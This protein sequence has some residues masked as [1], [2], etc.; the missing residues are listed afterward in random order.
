VKREYGMDFPI[1][2]LDGVNN[3]KIADLLPKVGHLGIKY[4]TSQK[5]VIQY[6]KKALDNDTSKDSMKIKNG[7]TVKDEVLEK[8]CKDIKKTIK[9]PLTKKIVRELLKTY[10]ETRI[11]KQIDNWNKFNRWFTFL[12]R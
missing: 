4:R 2:L 1:G 12:D 9:K 11:R 10:G 3:Q 5:A 6:L 7:E 8:L